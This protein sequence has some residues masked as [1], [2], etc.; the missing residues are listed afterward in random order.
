MNLKEE[1]NR[2]TV[3]VGDGKGTQKSFDRWQLGVS[4]KDGGEFSFWRETRIF[5]M[6]QRP[7]IN[8]GKNQR[9]LLILSVR[10]KLKAFKPGTLLC[11]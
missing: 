3:E 11:Q 5:R 2:K 4:R 6:E 8:R 7:G 9:L 1:P 10:W